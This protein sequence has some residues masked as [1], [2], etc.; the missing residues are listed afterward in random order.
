MLK[1][2]SLLKILQDRSLCAVFQPIMDM[3]HGEVIGFEGLAR[4]PAGSELAMPQDLF[5]TA[6]AHDLLLELEIL[7][8]YQVMSAFVAQSLPGKL[9]AN[10]SPYALLNG[11]LDDPLLADLLAVTNSLAGRIVFELT[12]STPQMDSADVVAGIRA[13]QTRGFSVALDDLGEGFSSLRLWSEARPHYV[14]IDKHFVSGIDKNPVNL[15]FVRAIKQIADKSNAILI[16]EGI[17]YRAEFLVLK[18]LGICCGQG[19]F[20]ARPIAQPEV[21]ASVAALDC[22]QLAYA[23]DGAWLKA[24]LRRGPQAR[25]L[26]TKVPTVTI[27]TVSEDAHSI[28]LAHPDLD[29]LPVLDGKITVGTINRTMVDKFS[30]QYVRELYARQSCVA[31]MDKAFIAV[32]LDMPIVTLSQLVLAQGRKRFADG[33]VL[34]HAG[35]YVGV[36]SNFALMQ[37]MTSLQIQEARYANPLTLLPGNVPINEQIGVLLANGERFYACYADLDNFKPFN[38]V[39]GYA[40]GDELIKL[41]ACVLVAV[42]DEDVDFVG[43]IGGDDFFVLFQSA[44]WEARSRQI[45]RDFDVAV[46]NY[47]H[48]A[49]LGEQNY[50]A[51]DRRGNRIEYVFPTLSIGA[52]PVMPGQYVSCHEISAVAAE[53]KKAAKKIA[54]SSL[55]ID[56]RAGALIATR[57]LAAA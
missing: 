27:Q 35:D 22:L 19:Y 52:V 18:E 37:E 14:K 50:S 1:R 2:D 29:M 57:V 47:V 44:D 39:F 10:I 43:H 15:Q 16:A 5:A 55:Y 42:A 4:G 32:E 51:E 17:E 6:I 3:H 41:T 8:L 30:R 36:G 53:V 26:L 33:F 25:M 56:N 54:G 46:A 34:T 45:L 49:S 28:L 23:D 9:F 31:F 21:T 7:C 20:I 40:H 11:A 48:Q 24:V 12:E 13:L 38:D